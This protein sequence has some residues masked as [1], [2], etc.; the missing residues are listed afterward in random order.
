MDVTHPELYGYLAEFK[1]P[2]DL[3]AA[4]SRTREA[5]YRNVEAHSPM[6]VEGLAEAIGFR[7]TRIAAIVF[8]G[9]LLGGIG[10]FAMQYFA[11]VMHYPLN[12]GGKP[13]NSWPAF[14]PVT[15]ECT[16]LAAAFA[17]VIGMLFLNG[18][19]RPYHP[20]FNVEEFSRA[21]V[22]RFFL[23]I[24]W[25]DEKFDAEQTRTFLQGLNPESLSEVRP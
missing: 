10:G 23:F 8:T 19:P 16:V 12:V 14:I 6:P 18:L 25:D 24:R 21:S 15:F 2:E 11:S 1:T 4:A 22:D 13:F 7:K 20:L 9:G 3:V 5:G 17:A